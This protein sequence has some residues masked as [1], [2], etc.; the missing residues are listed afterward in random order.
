M[1]LDYSLYYSSI[2]INTKG[3]KPVYGATGLGKTYGIK[4]FIKKTLA[5]NPFQKFIYITN[6]H[7]LIEEIYNELQDDYGIKVSYL[8]GKT[9][10][11]KEL[12]KSKKL[13]IILDHLIN[14]GFFN[15]EIENKEEIHY[16]FEKWLESLTQRE[17]EFL[18][19]PTFK[20]IEQELEKIYNRILKRLYQAFFSLKKG[21]KKLFETFLKDKNI[22]KIFPF[23]Q[24]ENDENT[25]VLVGTIQKFCYGFFDGKKFQKLHNLKHSKEDNNYVIFLDEFDF[26]ENEILSILCQEPQLQNSIEFVRFFMEDFEDLS[27]EEFWEKDKNLLAVKNEMQKTYDFVQ[28]MVDKYNFFFPRNRRFTFRDTDFRLGKNQQFVLF[29]NNNHPLVSESFYLEQTKE[30]RK[31][32]IVKDRNA[33]TVHSFAFFGMIKTAKE[34]LLRTFDRIRDHQLLMESLIKEFW[35]TKNDNTKGEYHRY[36]MEN[37]SYR[38][39][40]RKNPI[41]RDFSYFSGFSLITLKKESLLDPNLAT[42]EQLELILSPEAIIAELASK[43]LVFALSATSDIPRMI[44][45]FDMNWLELN[46]NF[47]QPLSTDIDLIERLKAEKQKIR[48]SKVSYQISKSIDENHFMNGIINTLAKTGYYTESGENNKS[49]NLR[50]DKAKD[51]FGCIDWIVNKSK[52]RTHLVFSNTFKR[53]LPFFDNNTDLKLPSLVKDKLKGQNFIVENLNAGFKVTYGTQRFNILFLNAKQNKLLGEKI[54]LRESYDNLFLDKSSEKVI[55]VTQYAT[56]S[57]GLNLRCLSEK[58]GEET[59]FEGI[60][61]LEPRHFWFDTSDENRNAALNNKKKVFWYFWKL[62]KNG[63]LGANRFENFLKKTNLKEFNNFYKETNEYILN[64][65]AL[66]HQALGRVDRKRKKLPLIEITLAKEVHNIFVDFL[67]KPIYQERNELIE[68]ER[69]TATFIL[70]LNEAIIKV[71]NKELIKAQ[72]SSSEDISEQQ[73]NSRGQVSKL[74]ERIKQINKGII[75]NEDAKAIIKTWNLVRNYV[76]KH[77]YNTI[78]DIRNDLTINF[79]ELTFETMLI[80]NDEKLYVSITD[81]I[82]Y[83]EKFKIEEDIFEWD[84]NGPYKYLIQNNFLADEFRNLGYSTSFNRSESYEQRQRVFTPYINQAILIGAIG[85][86]SIKCLLAREGFFCESEEKTP[87][88]LFELFDAKLEGLPIY[89]DFK[90]FSKRTQNLFEL[91]EDDYLYDPDF[92]SRRFL[93]KVMRKRN[94]IVAVTGD[95]S[96]KYL[97]IN[98]VSSNDV[99]SKYFDDQLNPV[100]F[101]VDSSIIVIPSAISEE[102][103]NETSIE[104]N[105]MISSLK[106]YEH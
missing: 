7:A 62:Y 1:D 90:N 92:D 57:N 97:I 51:F 24:F 23:V 73:T 59:D 79:K 63:E 39:I 66:F 88:K 36:I 10:S 68:R 12:Q 46:T 83:P 80:Q 15:Y 104:F 103:P 102:K 105:N 13:K 82:L 21:N 106:H 8:K 3:I 78:I 20:L 11:L 26:L 69:I 14:I 30:S 81:F 47:I 99:K 86:E 37:Y 16:Q 58:N 49:Q 29:Q 50:I 74:L 44:N 61:L 2:S 72:L 70:Q 94:R 98:F 22:W 76:L 38:A 67:T 75:Q 32:K 54:E 27:S 48:Q 5:K 56:A 65:M 52:N 84:L 34:R 9:E 91:K 89:I 28:G 4:E 100:D 95:E 45:S 55:L 64:Q 87:F 53:E 43:N 85:E 96:L 101:F 18:E 77:D 25:N 31:F 17:K 35:D 41:R 33:N 6:R 93:N 60:H 40:K 42:I 71:A 19:N